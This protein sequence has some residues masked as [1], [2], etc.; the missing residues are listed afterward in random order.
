MVDINFFRNVLSNELI[1][2]FHTP[3]SASVQKVNTE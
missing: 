3:L 1:N 2:V